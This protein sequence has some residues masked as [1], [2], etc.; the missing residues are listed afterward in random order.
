MGETQ[1]A[2][3]TKRET[4]SPYLRELF[5]LSELAVTPPEAIAYYNALIQ[6]GIQ[7]FIIVLWPDDLDTLQMFGQE[8]LPALIR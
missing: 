3:A 5:G 8:V 4:G 2:I 1:A 7:Y 6:A